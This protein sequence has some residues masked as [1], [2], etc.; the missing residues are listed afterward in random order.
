MIAEC[1]FFSVGTFIKNHIRNHTTGF[2]KLLRIEISRVY[3]LT[4]VQ[5]S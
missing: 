2:N 4:T 3:F 1:T 5:F